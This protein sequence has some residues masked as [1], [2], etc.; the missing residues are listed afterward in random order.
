MDLGHWVGSIPTIPT[1]SV[2]T[3]KVAKG[4]VKAQRTTHGEFDSHPT[5]QMNKQHATVVE[6]VDTQD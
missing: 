1:T 3:A 5:D 2:G 6:L 4:S